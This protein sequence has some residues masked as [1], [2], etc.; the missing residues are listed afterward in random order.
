MHRTAGP[1]GRDPKRKGK[2][3]LVRCWLAPVKRK[4]AGLALALGFSGSKRNSGLGWLRLLTKGKRPVAFTHA[5]GQKGAAAQASER[6]RLAAGMH[7]RTQEKEMGW[8]GWFH[9]R[10]WT[11]F[12]VHGKAMS[13]EEKESNTSHGTY[14]HVHIHIHKQCID[15]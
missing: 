11:G 8:C 6:L 2:H 1:P 4:A 9:V 10:L 3:G 15:E 14:V 7:V 12:H 5:Q 13:R